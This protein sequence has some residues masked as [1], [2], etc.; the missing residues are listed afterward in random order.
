MGIRDLRTLESRQDSEDALAQYLELGQDFVSY[1]DVK[2]ALY[3]E[4]EFLFPRRQDPCYH[5]WMELLAALLRHQNLDEFKQNLADQILFFYSRILNDD[6]Q[7]DID[8]LYS[9]RTQ[10]VDHL[11]QCSIGIPVP[12]TIPG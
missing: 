6:R 2:R 3:S 11:L 5:S 9:L 8:L 10:A 4:P 7:E 1:F 12:E